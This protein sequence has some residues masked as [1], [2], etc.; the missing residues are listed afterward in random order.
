MSPQVPRIIGIGDTSSLEDIRERM[1]MKMEVVGSGEYGW[2][3][4]SDHGNGGPQKM[5]PPQSYR[6][7]RLVDPPRF[8]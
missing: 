1:G 5:R 3:G 7:P 2:D 8:S 4:S 6:A